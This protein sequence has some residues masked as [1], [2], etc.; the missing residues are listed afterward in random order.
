MP[1]NECDIYVYEFEAFELE[2]GSIVENISWQKRTGPTEC[3][4][5]SAQTS[6]GTI[7]HPMTVYVSSEWTVQHAIK[8]A[9]PSGLNCNGLP[10]LK[11]Y[12]SVNT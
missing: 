7:I 9:S 10:L 6:F 2:I 1:F 4:D 5:N 3:V 12:F 8:P 11:I